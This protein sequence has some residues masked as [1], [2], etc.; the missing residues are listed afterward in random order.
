ME[1]ILIDKFRA[2]GSE[3]FVKIIS[4]DTSLLAMVKKEVEKLEAKWSRFIGDSEISLLN[5]GSVMPVMVSDETRDLVLKM[6]NGYRI[7]KGIFDPT[8]LPRLIEQGY[9]NS[10]SDPKK[11]SQ[12]K[13]DAKWPI[14]FLKTE[15]SGNLVFLPTGTTLDP[16]GIG[17]GLTADLICTQVMSKGA[18]GCLISAGGDIRVK[19]AGP[20]QGNWILAIED[21]IDKN[22]VIS[23][24]QIQDGA[25]ATSSRLKRKF[26]EKSNHLIDIRTGKS[27]NESVQAVSV[28][29]S[30]AALAEVLCKL[31][32][33]TSIEESFKIIENQ[34]SAALV[35]TDD[36]LVHSSASWKRYVNE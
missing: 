32:F 4:D 16:G 22:S 34:N 6:L 26:S 1:K 36:D 9:K 30:T 33:G 7:T 29:S 28:I 24:V 15:V 13:A 31:P 10:L 21:P 2:M 20:H 23:Q 18:L 25:V 17:K 12:I 27:A 5:N 3:F 14:D 19:G 35:V 11:S 8:V